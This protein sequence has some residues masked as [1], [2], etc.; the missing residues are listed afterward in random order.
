MSLLKK[1]TKR[2]VIKLR[3]NIEAVL[4]LIEEKF[5]NNKSFFAETIGVD[6][7]YL[8]SVLNKKAIDHSPKVCNGI[9]RYCK[10]NNLDETKYIFLE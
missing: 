3:I 7:S 1:L 4:Q 9:V 5:R 8:N 6:P 2:R 10:Q